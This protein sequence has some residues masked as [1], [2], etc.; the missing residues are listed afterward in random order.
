MTREGLLT[1][2][3]PVPRQGSGRK[4]TNR[5][6]AVAGLALL[7]VVL[8]VLRIELRTISWTDMMR[9][10]AAVDPTRLALAMVLTILNY[11]VLTGYDQAAFAYLGKAL[12]R[13]RIMLTSFLAYAISNNLSFAMLSGATVRY[14]FYSRWGVTAK[15][16]S[17]I[18]FSYSVTFW[19]GLFALGGLTLVMTPLRDIEQLP[20]HQVATVVGGILM[21]LPLAYLAAAATRRAPLRLWRLTLPQPSIGVATAQFA[22][23]IADWALIGAVLFVLLPPGTVPFPTFMGAF[24]IAILL[25]MASHVPGGMGVFEGLMVL[26]LKRYLAATQLLPALVVYRAVYYLVP[27]AVALVVLV[28]DELRQRH[29]RSARPSTPPSE[30]D[31][32]DAQRVVDGQRSTV[33]NLVFTGDKNLLFDEDRAAFVM[34]AVHGRTWVALGDPVGPDDRRSR[35]VRLFLERCREAGGAPVFYEISQ[36]HLHRY[37]DLGLASIKVGEEARVNL[38]T[39]ALEAPTAKSLRHAA[40]H[41]E[42]EGGV[43]RIVDPRDVPALLPQLRVVSDQWL[44]AKSAGEKGF[45]VGFF[46]DAYLQRFPIAVIERH[47]RIEAFANVWRG[48]D[49]VELSLDLMRHLR[50]APNGVMDALFAHLM[51]WGR[52]QGYQWFSLGT[53]PLSGFDRSRDSSLWARLGSFVYEHGETFYSFQGLRAYKQKFNPTWEP[54]YLAY[55]G[56]LRLPLILADVAALIAGGYRHIFLK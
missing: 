37:N 14:R 26:L 41:V 15:E 44:A 8:D 53:A 52:D 2:A 6:P 13:P 18:V 51:E 23:S 39:F 54:R 31:L 28:G 47:G 27:L 19:L 22:L 42:R 12:P 45:S 20:G 30:T 21:L 4:W 7:L 34:Y 46:D 25:G 33:A 29:L 9:D 32:R 5:L 17:R 56:G 40:R 10:L 3:P 38:Q 43:F 55:T 1:W 16:L 36:A 35:M 24:L 49:G 50:D 11:A 48:A